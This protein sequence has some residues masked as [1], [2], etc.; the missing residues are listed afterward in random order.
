[1]SNTVHRLY[2]GRSSWPHV[3][4]FSFVWIRCTVERQTDRLVF[5]LNPAHLLPQGFLTQIAARPGQ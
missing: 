3:S 2:Q 4:C 5:T 1:M